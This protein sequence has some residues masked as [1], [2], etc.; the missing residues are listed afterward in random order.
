MNRM[1]FLL[2]VAM[3]FEM[4]PAMQAGANELANPGFE[5]DAVMDAPPG[6]AVTGWSTFNGGGQASATLDPVRTGI[7]SLRL[8]GGGGFS[9]PGAFQTF[10]ASPGQLWD[11]QGYLLTK[12]L[13]PAGATFGL[14]KIV[15]GNGT[16]DLP[17]ASITI[18]Q[19]APAA[20]PGIESL[21]QLNS[22][23]A[24]NTWQFTHAQGVAPAG[25]IEVRIF[26]LFVDQVAGTGY[27]DDVQALLAGDFDND[28]DIDGV[29]LPVWRGAFGLT[30]AGDADG[31]N[32]SDGADMLLWQQALN[33][34]VAIPVVATVPEPTSALL[35]AA[36]LALVGCRR[37]HSRSY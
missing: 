15:F 19:A 26:A 1:R 14:L 21:P 29:D 27:V 34:P 37:I 6:G 23:S 25:T 4:I 11:V 28:K 35:L 3:T 13:L 2:V 31:D 33:A 32:D 9:V 36:G 20:N 30:T 5:T 22:T 18:G 17:A 12:D 7:G 10:P 8:P 16:G 24:L